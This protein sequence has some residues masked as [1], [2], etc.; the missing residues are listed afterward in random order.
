L[1]RYKKNGCANLC[2]ILFS[3]VIFEISIIPEFAARG[4]GL[5]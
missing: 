3:K 5:N 1:V 2:K 4:R